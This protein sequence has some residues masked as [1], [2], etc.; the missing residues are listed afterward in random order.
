MT[1][2]SIIPKAMMAERPDRAPGPL[3]MLVLLVLIGLTAC[4]D[5]YGITRDGCYVRVA[6]QTG[7]SFVVTW[8][9][10][11]GTER[12]FSG[13]RSR[14]RFLD[15]GATVR[16]EQRGTTISL[17]VPES[18]EHVFTIYAD[19]FATSTAPPQPSGDS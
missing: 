11:I 2:I 17:R 15:Q 16:V 3:M 5:G 18:G 19:A 10:G 9:N 13:E 6:N 8:P 12:V 14:Q 7:S 1:N 4:D